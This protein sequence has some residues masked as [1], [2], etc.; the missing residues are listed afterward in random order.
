MTKIRAAVVGYGNI[1]RFSIEAL[2]AAPD[3]EIAGVVRRNVAEI[4]AELAPYKVVT[5]IRELG[6]V[7][8]A[9]LATPTREVEKY[10][11]EYLAMG[12]NTVDSFDIHTSIIGLRRSLDAAAKKAGR[13]AVISAGWDPGSDSIVRTL[14]EAAAPKGLTYTNFGPGMSMGHTVCVKSKAGVKNALSMTMPKGDG[15]HRRMVYVELE[16]G[17]R[18]EDVAKAV[19]EDPYFASDE[20]HV[21]AVESVDA[22]K[23]MGHGVHMVRKGVSGKTQNQRFEFNMSI[24]NPALTAQLLVGVARASMRLTPGAYTMVEIPVIDLLPGE[25]E[26]LIAHLV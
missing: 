19:K 4:P 6:H 10:A 3:F 8:V 20:T 24:N 21:M 7:D 25:R 13:V 5:D 15:M 9:I 18:L 14:L 1:G 12:I 2:E 26:D 16:D 11:L 17:A 23:D 22:V